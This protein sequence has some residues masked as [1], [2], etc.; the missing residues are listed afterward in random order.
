M[1][2]HIISI[3][4]NDNAFRILYIYMS[5]INHRRLKFGPSVIL[6]YLNKNIRF[7]RN[8]QVRNEPS[9]SHPVSSFLSAAV[10]A[11]QQRQNVRCD[12]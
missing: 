3:E 2:L 11:A 12:F 9:R 10:N 6:K 1:K 5:S 7:Q 4:Q 8:D